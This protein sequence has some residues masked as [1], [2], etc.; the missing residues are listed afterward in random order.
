MYHIS[1]AAQCIYGWSDEGA[2]DG[3]GK[4]VSE[5]PGGWERVEGAWPLVCR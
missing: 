4:E 5:I 2:K 3:D 1:L